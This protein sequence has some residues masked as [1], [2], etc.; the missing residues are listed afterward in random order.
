MINE[1][2]IKIRAATVDDRDFI[3]SL[4]PRLVEFGPPAWRDSAQMIATDS[5]ILRDKLENPPEGTSVFVA[6]D[7]LGAPLGFIHLHPGHD[8]YQKEPHGHISDVIVAPAGEGQGIGRL[9]MAK[10]EEWARERGY[11]WLTLSVFAENVRAREIYK[12]LGYGE[13]IMKYVKEIE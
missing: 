1:P 10:A 4:A 8:Y 12:R 13:D 3:V 5:E 2:K 9:L 7:A 6:E 11:K